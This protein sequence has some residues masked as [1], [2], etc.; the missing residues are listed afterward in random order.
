MEAMERS[1]DQLEGK[2]EVYEHGRN[3]LADE[4][5]ALQADHEVDEE[6]ARMKEK[7]STRTSG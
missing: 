6:L 2:V 7:L 4:I 1:L 3:S 5:S